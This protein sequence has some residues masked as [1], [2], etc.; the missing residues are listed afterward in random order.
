VIRINARS[1]TPSAR[2]V[3]ASAFP[4]RIYFEDSISEISSG[5][6]DSAA[7]IFPAAAVAVQD[8]LVSARDH[9]LTLGAV[10]SRPV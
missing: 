3:F 5:N 9:P 6:S 10:N 2:R 8:G 1:M 7:T 4:R